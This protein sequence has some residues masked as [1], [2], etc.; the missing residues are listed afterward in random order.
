MGKTPNY[1]DGNRFLK[2]SLYK[3]AMTIC[4]WKRAL[5]KSLFFLLLAG[6]L[7]SSAIAEDAG[8]WSSENVTGELLALDG[9]PVLIGDSA[10]VIDT[11]WK[12]RYAPMEDKQPI[13]KNLD[14]TWQMPGVSLT[15]HIVLA[16]RTAEFG[17]DMDY[18]EI[19]D[20][21]MVENSIFLSDYATDFLRPLLNGKDTLNF[22]TLTASLGGQRVEITG[23]G[24]GVWSLCL[25]GNHP[26][27]RLRFRYQQ[28]VQGIPLHQNSSL[29][30]RVFPEAEPPAT[31]P[32]NA[33]GTS[34][35]PGVFPPNALRNLADDEK[36]SGWSGQ[37]KEND[38]R[39]LKTGIRSVFGIPF[40]I[41][42]KVILLRSRK[43]PTFPLSSGK[44]TFGKPECLRSIFVL[45]TGIWSAG[46]HKTAAV[47]RITY[48]DGTSVDIPV[49]NGLEIADWWGAGSLP[50]APVGIRATNGAGN[51]VGVYL[52]RL[53]ALDTAKPVAALEMISE[54][55]GCTPVLLAATSVRSAP[56]TSLRVDAEVQKR[57][58]KLTESKP[59]KDYLPCRIAWN[60]APENDSALNVSCLNHRPAG[61]Y[62]FL[63]QHGENFEFEKRPGVP[64]R[65]WGTNFA[66]WGA[67]P[68]KELAPKLAA[69][70]AAQGVNIVRIHLYANRGGQLCNTDGSLG[71]TNLDKMFYLISELKKQGIYI[72]MDINDGMM[73]DRLLK[74]PST[75][76]P[77]EHLKACSVFD[78][79][80]RSAV[81]RLAE[82][83]FLRKNPYTGLAMLDDPAIAMFECINEYSTFTT[84]GSAW[85]DKEKRPRYRQEIEDLW[86]VFLREN[87][88]PERPLPQMMNGCAADRKFAQKIDSEYL[89]AIISFMRNHGLKV[90]ISGTNINW[91]LA[92]IKTQ[93][94]AGV[95]FFGEHY[96]WAHPNFSTTPLTYADGACAGVP[97]WQM[98]YH[99]DLARCAVAGYPAVIGEW[100]N[101]FPNRMRADG[102]PL[103]AAYASYQN[104]DALIFYGA[105][106]SCDSGEWTRFRDNPIIMVHSQQTDPS[107]WG[108][109]QLG[110]LIFRRGDVTPAKQ[111]LEIQVPENLLYEE[112]RN[113]SAMGFLFQY[114]RL[115]LKFAEKGNQL[116][117]IANQFRSAEDR[118][119]A[120]KKSL[121]GV[122]KGGR[123]LAVSDT[124]ELF[125]QP[126][127]ALFWIDTPR[128][129]CVTGEL[130]RL[131]SGLHTL[132]GVDLA[133]PLAYGTFAVTSLD[134]NAPM[135]KADR[136]LVFAVGNS[137][138]AGQIL[139][140]GAII[141]NGKGQVL[142]ESFAASVSVASVKPGTVY[143]LD[144][145]SG[146][147]IRELPSTFSDGKIHFELTG[148]DGTIYYE[149]VKKEEKRH[150]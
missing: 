56:E 74:R 118:Y 2:Q 108:L 43:T 122:L 147:R 135:E 54:N 92:Q 88:L 101:C 25:N 82:L 134:E 141:N 77:E 69:G 64:V 22:K 47:Y 5:R 7:I 93:Q 115:R 19:P 53:G 128:S 23:K 146:A 131:D 36:F 30:F 60:T 123:N 59:G 75:F 76:V 117:E 111:M 97:V 100:N 3:K 10:H 72:Y 143:A 150:D 130:S 91:Q 71:E 1:L 112:P 104:Y 61:K 38:L 142:T 148:K 132:K 96:Y 73:Y 85:P 32:S 136:L 29:T 103:M 116:F 13:R 80:L 107:T 98:P 62:G 140:G 44:I 95:D 110:A 27:S 144:S 34:F 126:E 46:G 109:S 105:T 133:T 68:D 55:T 12:I 21:K 26:D 87:K 11:G 49:R 139:R 8:L 81:I 50:N 9:I 42:G 40:R 17:H 6:T 121:P 51:S 70:M 90:P 94:K 120:V 33:F 106:G 67:Y 86:S 28:T 124:E 145:I 137:M 52:F 149:I 127:P 138:N 45:H 114:G 24:D 31:E 79:E 39:N 4:G 35:V 65:F 18:R 83:L 66:I 129:R 16:N 119:N 125:R 78:P 58:S 20:G 57:S 102:I 48:A 99:G 63:K 14:T 41:A 113:V 84:W 15:R 89:N 37:G